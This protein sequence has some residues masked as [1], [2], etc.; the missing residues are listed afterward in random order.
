MENTTSEGLEMDFKE[1]R[2]RI[3]VLEEKS[4][5]HSSA[6]FGI[7]IF[8]FIATLV[9]ALFAVILPDVEQQMLFLGAATVLA[10]NVM[11]QGINLLLE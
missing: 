4:E 6:H 10:V 3:R 7:I 1:L 9:F 8:D 2:D 5:K 11:S